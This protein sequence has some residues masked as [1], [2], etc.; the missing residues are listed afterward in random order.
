MK[1]NHRIQSGLW[2]IALV[3]GI[4]VT[5][6]TLVQAQGQQVEPLAG[7]WKTWVLTSGSQLRL[8]PPPS[9]AVIE[10]AQLRALEAQ[11]DLATLDTVNFWD[12]GSPAYRWIEMT[13]PLGTGSV[14]SRAL[15]LLSVAIY[16][17][18]IAAWDSKYTYNRLRPSQVDPT[19]TTAVPT[20][21]S[22]SY[23]SEH[24]VVA[25]AAS[26]I[27]AYLFPAQAQFYRD[28]AE[29][30][31]RS[32][33]AAGVQ[34]PSDSSAGL[35]LGR[36]VA[37][38]VIERARTD[39]SDR[40]WTGTVP[41]GPCRWQSET[42]AA[43]SMPLAGTWKTWVLRSGDQFRPAPPPDC[44]SDEGKA[45]AAY[46]RDFA[47]TFNTNEA[48]FYWQGP[49][50]VWNP[51]ISEKIVAYRLDTN[52]PR[53]ARAYALMNIA[54]YDSIVA[55]WDAKYTYWQTRPYQQGAKPVFP[56]PNHPSYPGAHACGSSASAAVLA[57]LF[58][59]D[60]TTLAQR[61]AEAAESRIWAGIHYRSDTAAGLALGRSVAQLV[62]DRAR[63]DG[64]QLD[65]L[66]TG[67]TL[68]PAGVQTGGSF[69]ATIL[70]TNLA[71]NTYFDIRF[72]RPDSTTDEV[73]LNWQ[74][75][76]SGQHTVPM[77][78]PTGT[79]SVTGVRSHRVVNEQSG[80]FASV[81]ATLL[82]SAAPR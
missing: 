45:E 63:D 66:A 71:A 35:D 27:L 61:A 26:E 82:I 8:P 24:A 32:R 36:A 23:P 20:P 33:V 81:S 44:N 42:G 15:S 29:E 77:G 57:Y 40:P 49:R 30:A 50:S 41:T 28:K 2:A 65:S 62:I 59:R 53:A 56:T 4:C 69:T 22:P 46:V 39:G 16:D 11:R 80:S 10:I 55:C 70:G 67:M 43:P 7:T 60:A 75:G 1:G 74:R 52:P 48:A 73:A 5:C 34:Y 51:T 78:T 19:L 3:A 47:R 64:S 6:A 76:T 38:K 72:R 21:Q 54:W 79:W 14:N 9:S 68:G 12:T 17:A 13:Y 25:G 18:T 37:A 58:P 31:A